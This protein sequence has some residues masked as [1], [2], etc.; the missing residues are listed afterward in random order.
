VT[1]PMLLQGRERF[2]VWCAPCHGVLAGGDGPVA[3]KMRLRAPPSLLA[4]RAAVHPTL[5][6][7]REAARGP[8]AASWAAL[9]RPPRDYFTI[10]SEGY[11]LMPAYGA[12]LSA[13]ER[14]AVIAYLRAL[15]F[16]QRAPLAAAEPKA[17]ARLLHGGGAP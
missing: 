2:E 10:I 14:W 13:Q 11:G 4:P 7:P 5:G 1:L 12:Q 6:S 9:P 15:A 3:K 16:S 17:R 8:A